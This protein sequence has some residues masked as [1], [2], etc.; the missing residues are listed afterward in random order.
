[1][2]RVKAAEEAG[3]GQSLTALESQRAWNGQTDDETIA[4]QYGK[5]HMAVLYI[6]EEFSSDAPIEIIR[7]IGQGMSLSRAI[8][9]VLGIPYEELR[10]RVDAWTSEWTDPERE[11]M[12]GYVERMNSIYNAVDEHVDRRNESLSDSQ[13]TVP[14]GRNSPRG[15]GRPCR[16]L[17]RF[18]HSH[19]PRIRKGASR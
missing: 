19:I 2:D 6:S 8:Q 17:S 9:E 18:A 5:A 14:A 12:R 7:N 11:E 4:L 13:G 16:H 3:L 1:M 15:N 10:R